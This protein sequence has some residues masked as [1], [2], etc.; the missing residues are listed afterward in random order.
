MCD[1]LEKKRNRYK[2]IM[3]TMSCSLD[4][5]NQRGFTRIIEQCGQHVNQTKVAAF[6]YRW[7]PF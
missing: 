6:L 3:D 7:C 1:I 5:R 2:L 4:L